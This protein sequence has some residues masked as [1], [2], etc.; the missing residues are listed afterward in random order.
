LDQIGDLISLLYLDSQ[1]PEDEREIRE[2]YYPGKS[3]EDGHVV[4]ITRP[5][6]HWIN[7]NIS[8]SDNGC[9]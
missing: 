1:V 6:T 3:F 4:C 7:G 5:K 8:D 2:K 9:V